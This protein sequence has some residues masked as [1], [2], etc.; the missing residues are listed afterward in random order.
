MAAEK[1]EEGRSRSSQRTSA[2]CSGV[3]IVSIRVRNVSND[4]YFSA[5][6]Q[7]VII[8]KVL[9]LLK[10]LYHDIRVIFSKLVSHV[11]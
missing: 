9:S 2:N 6:D 3:I 7:H 5:I 4:I 8:K 10:P 11:T 1:E